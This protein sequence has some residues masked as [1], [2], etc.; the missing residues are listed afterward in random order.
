MCVLFSVSCLMASLF[1][2]PPWRPCH[3]MSS[4]GLMFSLLVPQ[5]FTFTVFSLH[6]FWLRSQE[7]PRPL[8]LVCHFLFFSWLLSRFSLVISILSVICLAG[9]FRVQLTLE[10]L[11]LE[12][13]RCTYRQ[14]FLS[15]K[16]SRAPWS[17]AGWICGCRG[18]SHLED[19]LAS[20]IWINPDV[21]R[22]HLYLSSWCCWDP[23]IYVLIYFIE[24]GE[25]LDII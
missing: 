9:V 5:R 23:W 16:Y 14:V 20:S 6:Y 1:H 12:L 3:W 21:F 7:T 25:F 17:V 10:E 24:F 15:S 19:R 8:L 4:S 11:G 2:R 18:T 13:F 22:G